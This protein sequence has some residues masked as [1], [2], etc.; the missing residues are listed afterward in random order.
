MLKAEMLKGE[1]GKGK[2]REKLKAENAEGR[3]EQSARPSA[4]NLKSGNQEMESGAIV[5]YFFNDTS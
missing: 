4:F 1:R 3:A 2:K 5:C